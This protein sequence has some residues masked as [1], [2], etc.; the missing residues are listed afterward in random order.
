MHPADCIELS[1][2]GVDDGVA[3]AALTPGFELFVIVLPFNVAVF[4][5][6]GL[7]HTGYVSDLH[8]QKTVVGNLT[9]HKA[10]G[11]GR[12]CRNPAKR[13]HLSKSEYLKYL[14]QVCYWCCAFLLH[15]WQSWRSGS[16]L[17]N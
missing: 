17:P 1:H 11:Q 14:R 7:I 12:V 10:S 16:Q 5:F 13:P 9:R 6:E 15:V 3:S 4:R 2:S 8:L